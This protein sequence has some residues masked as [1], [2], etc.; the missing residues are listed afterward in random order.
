MQSKIDFASFPRPV[1]AGFFKNNRA[2]FLAL[3]K[4]SPKFPS[5]GLIFLKGPVEVQRY[6]DDSSL[7]VNPEPF[8]FYLFGVTDPDTYA[9]I[10][11][12]TG[13]A[14]LFVRLP[15]PSES[16]WTNFKSL[17]DFKKTYEIDDAK[18]TDELEAFLKNYGDAKSFS[19]YLNYG[20]SVYSQAFSATP[21]EDFKDLLAQ[22][23]VDDSSLYEYACESRVLKSDQEIEILKDSIALTT[24]AHETVMKTVLPGHTEAQISNL[25][26]SVR[27]LHGAS[28][29][30]GNI[31]CAGHNG[32]YLHY[33]PDENVKF[34]NGD[35]LLIDSAVKVNG[36]C[37]DITR[38]Y[39]VNG[40]FTQRQKDIYNIVLKAQADSLAATKAGVLYQDTHIV[41][42]RTIVEGLIKLGLVRGDVHTAWEKR[43]SWYFM[44][45]GLGH[46]IGLYTHD[47]P[48]LV[49][50]ENNFKP[51]PNMRVAIK[52]ILEPGMVITC[53]PGI[54]FNDILLEEGYKDPNAGPL[55]VKEVIEQYKSEVGGVR[56]EDMVVIT[57]DGNTMLSGDLIKTVDE[58]E[59]FMRDR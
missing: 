33:D 26:T 31:C 50:K 34:K 13:L 29:A 37:S 59:Q 38:T 3:L 35:L 22:Y 53:E 39:P 41:A 57:K 19:I 40:K 8:F 30:Y 43:V 4:T 52:R 55:L 42:E 6:D 17:D 27:M 51:Y 15:D 24:H 21:R 44:P 11:L 5:N 7:G 47:L 45:H 1:P 56:I 9:M 18:S 25:F 46:Y 28:L 12:K 49:A 23:T 16:F 10:D 36:Y 14:T 2:R 54:Y 48:G 58:I 32:S 20:K